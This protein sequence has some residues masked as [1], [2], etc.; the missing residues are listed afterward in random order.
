LGFLLS[1]EKGGVVVE[2]LQHKQS[3]YQKEK[4]QE[5]FPLGFPFW[6]KVASTFPQNAWLPQ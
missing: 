2:F 1:A 4:N 5:R 6:G 3:Q